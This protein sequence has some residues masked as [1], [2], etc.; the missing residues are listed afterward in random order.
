MRFLFKARTQDGQIK[1]GIVEAADRS[2]AVRVLQRE[3]LIPISIQKEREGIKLLNSIKRLWE[4]L[5]QKEL[6]AF[7]RELATLIH[8]KV[9]VV[10]AL[11][12]I[13]E[14]SDNK[15]LRLI[16]KDIAADI[17]D[18]ATFSD[19]LAK[20]PDVFSPLIVSVMR[21][22]EASG[23]LQNSIMFVADN[24]EKN[25]QLTSRIRSAL[26]YPSFVITA[27]AIIGFLTASFILPNLT[28]VIKDFGISDV[29][30]YTVAV[31]AFGD[32]M[33]QYWWAVLIVVFALI[34]AFIYYIR[35]DT[36][37]YEW[38]HIK[39][40]LPV[41]GRLFR[42]IY[43]SRFAQNFSLLLA[44]GIP[45]V[46]ALQITADVVD[47]AVYQEII[48]R[49]AENVKA[50]GT[51]SETFLEADAI[52]SMMARMIRIGEETG[53]LDETLVSVSDLYEEEISVIT[54]NLT[55]MLEPVLIVVLGI[56]VAILVV[57]ILLPIYNI[58]GNL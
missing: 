18:G 46:R 34:G 8:A 31:M 36:G 2:A 3:E 15:F 57:A 30:W 9:P 42:M 21:S 53:K 47:N 24:L 28:Q 22:G 45:V 20:Y 25:Y 55:T 51:I 14:Q 5:S 1:E 43:V 19:A 41:F 16:V 49:A 52:P 32:F 26:F 35:T 40:K 50:G 27:A 58:A 10:Q 7:F 12:A 33:S 38:D 44:G 4:G 39:L 11:R 54:R 56:G 13:E 29:P 6:S 17:E 23:N 37:S 48:L